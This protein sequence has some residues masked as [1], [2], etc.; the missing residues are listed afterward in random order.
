MIPRLLAAAGLAL[1]LIAANWAIFAREAL[2]RDG[3]VLLLE[4][5]PVDPRSLMQGDYM[6]L[7]FQ[8]A[9]ELRA[10]AADDATDGF[11]VLRPDADG[12][13]RYQRIQPGIQPLAEGELAL[14]YRIRGWRVRLV[15]DAWFFQEGN[16]ERFEAAR[17]GEFRVAPDGSALLTAL[18]DAQRDPIR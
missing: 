5:A 6:A 2:L 13:G 4:L 10:A 18:R 15:T 16:G 7:D 1:A 17:F 3:R 11:V 9:G 14:R 8:V 12:V